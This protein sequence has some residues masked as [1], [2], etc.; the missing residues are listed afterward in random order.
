MHDH[1]T[2]QI[3]PYRSHTS[4]IDSFILNP[5]ALA[6]VIASLM[7]ELQS[8]DLSSIGATSEAHEMAAAWRWRKTMFSPPI[9]SHGVYFPYVIYFSGIVPAFIW[10]HGLVEFRISTSWTCRLL[11]TVFMLALTNYVTNTNN[12]KGCQVKANTDIH[13]VSIRH[14]ILN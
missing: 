9:E 4:E 10:L 1:C 2:Y 13:K 5:S 12:A 11:I 8:S 14:P 3:Q 6:T 7:L